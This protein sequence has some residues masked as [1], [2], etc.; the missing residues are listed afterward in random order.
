MCTRGFCREN[1][2][3]APIT[4]SRRYVTTSYHEVRGVGFRRQIQPVDATDW[5]RR[6]KK[7]RPPEQTAQMT[8][9]EFEQ[10]L[11]LG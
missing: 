10:R 5:R 9:R 1:S 11:T 3:I 7:V 6:K 2:T 4:T 8:L